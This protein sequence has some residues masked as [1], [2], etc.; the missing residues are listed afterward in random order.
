MAK[1]NPNYQSLD[2]SKCPTPEKYYYSSKKAAK[3]WI[4]KI[5]RKTHE[6][7]NTPYRC[8]CGYWHV[9]S[10]PS[11]NQRISKRIEKVKT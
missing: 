8:K 2:R 9:T 1:R 10:R 5:A 4:T 7:R 6:T 11:R 3:K